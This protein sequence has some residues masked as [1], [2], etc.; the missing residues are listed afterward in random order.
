MEFIKHV[1]ERVTKGI[2]P[3]IRDFLI[4]AYEH[5]DDHI[6]ENDQTTKEPGKSLLKFQKALKKVPL[7]IPGPQLNKYIEEVEKNIKNFEQVLASVFVA[8]A[9]MIINAV[10]I[11]SKKKSLNVKIPTKVEF[12]HQCFINVA[13]N[14][15]ENPFVMKVN[16]ETER[17][18]ELTERI[19]HCLQETISEMVPLP[20][21]LQE[22]IPMSGGSINFG[23]GDDADEIGEELAPPTAEEMASEEGVT[24]SPI[25]ASPFPAG[26]PVQPVVTES[27]EISVGSEDLFSD[28]PEEKPVPKVNG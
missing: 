27:K 8:Y 26:P 25:T 4:D 7:W 28:A 2:T 15:Y 20:E 14:L 9:K 17:S 10:R 3:V 22:H 23:G 13:H 5:S 16:D 1:S 19:G 6:D 12:I 18:K 24:P 11:T 21:I